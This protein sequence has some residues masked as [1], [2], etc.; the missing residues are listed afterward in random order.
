MMMMMISPKV[1]LTTACVFE[2]FPL[3]VLRRQRRLKCGRQQGGRANVTVCCFTLTSEIF[4][5]FT[6]GDQTLLLPRDIWF[7]IVS[8]RQKRY[9]DGTCRLR[10]QSTESESSIGVTIG[11]S[12][13]RPSNQSHDR[14]GRLSTGTNDD[15]HSDRLTNN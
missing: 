6:G 10:T 15:I 4:L 13:K 14:T 5:S 12:W 1:M 3:I 9:V 11:Q 2:R 7:R 8:L